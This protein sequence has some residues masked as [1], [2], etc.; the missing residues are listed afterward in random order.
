MC[1]GESLISGALKFSFSLSGLT[2]LGMTAVPRCSA[3]AMRTWAVLQSIGLPV[4]YGGATWAQLSE[5]MMVDKKA[6]GSRLRFVILDGIGSPIFLDGPDPAM[7]LA[8]F[9]QITD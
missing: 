5:A 6:R 7:L 9:G 1:S 4:S 8:A 3:Q 2:D